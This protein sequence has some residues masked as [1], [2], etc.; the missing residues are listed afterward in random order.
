MAP[1]NRGDTLAQISEIGI[2][3]EELN[4]DFRDTLR[5]I[6]QRAEFPEVTPEEE[7]AYPS[8]FEEGV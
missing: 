8:L 6:R 5:T 4:P 3:Y 2:P 1:T 7:E